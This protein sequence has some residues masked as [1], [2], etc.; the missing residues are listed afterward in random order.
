MAL[1][2]NFHVIFRMIAAVLLVSVLQ[3]S[4]AEAIVFF[5]QT[6][7]D[8]DSLLYYSIYQAGS[9]IVVTDYEKYYYCSSSDKCDEL[10]QYDD[11]DV[12]D[13][14]EGFGTIIFRKGEGAYCIH[15]DGNL[16]LFLKQDAA[17]SDLEFIQYID[18]FGMLIKDSDGSYFTHREGD[19]LYI[20]GLTGDEDFKYVYNTS[21]TLYLANQYGIYYY[22][23]NQTFNILEE[24]GMGD[25]NGLYVNHDGIIIQKDY[26]IL[27][28]DVNNFV[29]TVE[30]NFFGELYFYDPIGLLS[31]TKRNGVNIVGNSRDLNYPVSE[32]AR[33]VREPQAG[34]VVSD[35]NALYRYVW[36]GWDQIQLSNLDI[37]DS[38][39][40]Q[41]EW[42]ISHTTVW[43]HD[44]FI[45]FG[46][47]SIFIWNDLFEDR[48]YL[49]REA[50]SISEYWFISDKAL[51]LYCFSSW[52]IIDDGLYGI[53][54]GLQFNDLDSFY[55]DGDVFM[56][57]EQRNGNTIYRLH[58]I[59]VENISARALDNIHSLPDDHIS[60]LRW[61]SEYK[62]L[63]QYKESIRLVYHDSNGEFHSKPIENIVIV[64]GECII[65]ASIDPSELPGMQVIDAGLAFYLGGLVLNFGEIIQSDSSSINNTL[66][67][68]SGFCS[69]L[70]GWVSENVLTSSLIAWIGISILLFIFSRW[71]EFAWRIARDRI[72]SR[73][74]V[75]LYIIFRYSPWAQ[76][77]VMEKW[78][79]K[80]RKIVKFDSCS[81]YDSCRFVETDDASTPIAYDSIK[82]VLLSLNKQ[83]CMWIKNSND[84]SCTDLFDCMHAYYFG[85]KEYSKL[86]HAYKEYKFVPFFI[87]FAFYST[88]EIDP[89]D[90]EETMRCIIHDAIRK[91]GFKCDISMIDHFFETKQF[92]IIFKVNFNYSL[93]HLIKSYSA[94][95][96]DIKFLVISIDELND[97][98]DIFKSY[99]LG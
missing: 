31:C 8:I 30:Y 55:L 45:T 82:S 69:K 60:M 37:L 85:A 51:L 1:R 36:N 94:L 9:N 25:I 68:F 28:V 64:D 99:Q 88:Y 87:D 93:I 2:N 43:H 57:V 50:R 23:G 22:D 18:K 42:G 34:L 38:L 40:S 65:S 78:F 98:K 59:N 49:P 72:L 74:S 63:D 19:R 62:Y 24:A 91:Q 54:T 70:T 81:D 89:N 47:D 97:Y 61:S 16:E 83:R 73:I 76:R 35:D 32:C 77:W 13:Y 52:Y 29:Q 71:S 21:G 53:P 84:T 41:D 4:A 80:H 95:L 46:Y 5:E 90:Y 58:N 96:T 67:I 10:I 20:E 44:H 27:S 56:R 17:L 39:Y 26:K 11:V 33:F 12:V 86:R 7:L 75:I 3:V 79:Q 15:D 6:D 66:E 48:I 92:T 14:F